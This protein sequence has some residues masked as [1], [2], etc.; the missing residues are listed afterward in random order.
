MAKLHA[1]ES[2][3][4]QPGLSRIS[5]LTR[6]LG[7]PQQRLS[8]KTVHITGT[9]GKG[10]VA[11]MLDAILRA[12]GQKTALFTSP[13]LHSHT[14][15]YRIN[16]EPVP[17][18]DFAR[19]F[20]RVS[21]AIDAMTADGTASPTEFEAVTALALLWFAEQQVDT[22]VIETGMGGRDDSTNVLDAPLAI[23]TNAGMDHM[24][25]LGNTIEEIAANKAGV[26][27]Q[28]AAAVT[29]ADG[30]ALAVIK[31]IAAAKDASLQVLG[32]DILVTPRQ[33]SATGGV[34]D[35]RTPAGEYKEL[36]VGLMGEH[37]LSNAALAVWAAE[38]RGAS[39]EAIRTGLADV[40]WP[41]RLEIVSRQPLILL[42]GAHNYP[43]IRTLTA[44]LERFWPE[45]KKIFVLAMLADKEK[46]RCLDELLPLAD[47]LIVTRSPYFS[48]SADW[49]MPYE[50][51]AALGKEVYANEDVGAAL[52]MATDKVRQDEMIVVCGSLYMVAE[53][54][55][56]LLPEDKI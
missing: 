46:A 30:A 42:D 7:S 5:E 53:A 31:R 44:A 32:E 36:S 8:P 28:G 29:A 54:R 38:K 33:L 55:D 16:G 45:K 56:I 25:Y 51:A 1:L 24:A 27:K 11:A 43:G 22:A 9:N 10:S 2:F 26:I 50:Y 17:E 21:E 40:R 4:I 39:A 49:R 13:H 52:R 47:K 48:R 14:E 12:A 41:A 3:G 34:F 20:G 19:L 23:I 15:R 37:Q 6:R 35:L 18:A